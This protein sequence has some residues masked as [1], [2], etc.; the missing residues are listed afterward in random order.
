MAVI[1]LFPSKRRTQPSFML[2][3]CSALL[4]SLASAS[5]STRAAAVVPVP[6]P[7]ATLVPAPA[8]APKIQTLH[9]KVVGSLRAAGHY[10]AIAGLLDSFPDSNIIKTGMTLFA[11]ND[12]AFSNVQMNSTTYLQTL[13]RYHASTQIYSYQGLLNL[14]VGTKMQTAAPNVVI[15]I[16]SDTKGSYKLDDS[17]LVDPDIYTDQTISVQGIDS[18]LNTAKYNKGIVAPEAAPAPTIIALPP[19]VV[20]GPPSPPGTDSGTPG[21]PGSDGTDS[22]DSAPQTTNPNDASSLGGFTSAGMAL[23]ILLQLVWQLAL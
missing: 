13:L 12:N 2:T 16:T 8:P 22:P 18:V 3:M 4:F 15:V 5:P 17:T 11:P 14:P 9:E 21:A 23:W 19:S 20:A 7:T 6:A 10:G 1:D